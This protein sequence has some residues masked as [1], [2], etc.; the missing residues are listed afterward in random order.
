MKYPG[1]FRS[2]YP[3]LRGKDWI[4]ALEP[5]DLKAFVE[6]GLQ[7]T[8]HGRKGGLALVRKYGREH[9]QKIARVGAI[10]TNGLKEWRRK[11]QEYHDGM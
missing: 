11:V 7:E 4:K 1:L 3:V 10:A 2:R 6:I 9:M 5:D 8:D